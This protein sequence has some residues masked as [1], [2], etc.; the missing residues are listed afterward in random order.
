MR[1]SILLIFVISLIFLFGCGYEDESISDTLSEMENKHYED[2]QDLNN[3][4]NE[5]EYKID[6]QDGR[7][8]DLEAEIEDLYY[9]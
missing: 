9:Q 8:N 4:I 2:I 6:E 5:L 1:K 3:Y 7:I